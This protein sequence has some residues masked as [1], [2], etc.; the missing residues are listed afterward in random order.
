MSVA[1]TC[2]WGHTIAR[3]MLVR[4]QPYLELPDELLYDLLL[5][6]EPDDLERDLWRRFMS[7]LVTEAITDIS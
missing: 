6:D 4:S 1:S 2:T 7:Q 3:Q 5:L